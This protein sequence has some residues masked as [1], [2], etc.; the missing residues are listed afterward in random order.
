MGGALPQRM[1][2]ETATLSACG[3][4]YGRCRQNPN[5]RGLQCKRAPTLSARFAGGSMFLGIISVLLRVLNKRAPNRH[6]H[7]LGRQHGRRRQSPW[8]FPTCLACVPWENPV[9]NARKVALGRVALEWEAGNT[10][11][12]STKTANAR[13]VLVL[14]LY[15]CNH[16]T[17]NF[18][19][20]RNVV[21][22]FETFQQSDYFFFRNVRVHF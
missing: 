17:F 2:G 21:Q 22:L 19:Y 13:L 10:S 3:W 5:C 16:T 20:Q 1:R 6:L 11:T 7:L 9:C 12:S 14:S 4:Y 18:G 15:F 8:G